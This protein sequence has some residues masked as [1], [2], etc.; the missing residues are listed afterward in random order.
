MGALDGPV[1]VALALHQLAV[2][3]AV[4]L[5]RRQAVHALG[6]VL[7]AVLVPV[8]VGILVATRGREAFFGLR[9]R[10]GARREAFAPKRRPIRR[11]VVRRRAA[12]VRNAT[13]RL[14]ARPTIRKITWPN[15]TP[16]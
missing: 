6:V 8:L 12:M 15:A 1:R 13:N 3:R 14:A 9:A 16:R 10:P 11:S 4:A 2:V 5:G 7:V